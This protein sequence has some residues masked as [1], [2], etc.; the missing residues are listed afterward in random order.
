LVNPGYAR[1]P[2]ASRAFRGRE[3]ASLRLT[4]ARPPIGS[5]SSNQTRTAPLWRTVR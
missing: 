1:D 3:V 2:A 4:P 5:G